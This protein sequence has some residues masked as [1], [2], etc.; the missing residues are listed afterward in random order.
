MADVRNFGNV[1][2]NADRLLIAVVED[3]EDTKERRV[4]LVYDTGYEDSFILGEGHSLDN[5]PL[6]KVIRG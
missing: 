6:A 2:I 3:V 4:K 5:R 1:A